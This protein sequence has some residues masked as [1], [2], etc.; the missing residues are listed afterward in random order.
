MYRNLYQNKQQGIVNTHVMNQPVTVT[1][2]LTMHTAFI[3]RVSSCNINT[4]SC[5]P[6]SA[7]CKLTSSTFFVLLFTVFEQTYSVFI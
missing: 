6:V 7:T 4:A 5:L 2:I 3:Y 1:S